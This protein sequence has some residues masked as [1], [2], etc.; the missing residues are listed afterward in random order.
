MLG[1]R[2]LVGCCAQAGQQPVPCRGG[3]G[4]G[5]ES[6]EG[7][8]ADYEQGGGRIEVV[9]RRVQ[10]DRVDIGDEPADQVGRGVV[11]QRLGGHRRSQVRAADAD[12]DDGPD[13]LPGGTDPGAGADA[14]REIAHPA[15]HGVHVAGDILAVHREGLTFGQ[16]QRDME[17]G[18]VFGGVD[19]FAG[20]HGV[21]AGLHP[22]GSGHAQ[23]EPDRLVGDAVLG[24]IEH[25]IAG[26]GG[27]AGRPLGVAGEE[28]AQVSVADVA[29]V[30]FERLPLGRGGEIHV[31]HC[32]GG[33]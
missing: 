15:Q 25:Q 18:P 26:S 7:L 20:E 29:E 6:G 3:I 4:Q 31:R 1:H 33:G 27:Q 5:L 22:G 14:V 28:L 32:R 8:G 12:V 21:A 11:G 24:V 19:V 16:A 2:A 23:Q 30:R 9:G 17:D 13:A 10:V